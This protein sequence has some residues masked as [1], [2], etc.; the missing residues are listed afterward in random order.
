[1]YKFDWVYCAYGGEAVRF[2]GFDWMGVEA[3]AGAVGV[4]AGFAGYD[5]VGWGIV[6]NP[7]VLGC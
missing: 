2:G 3:G 5:W 4:G 1:V 6:G 7:V